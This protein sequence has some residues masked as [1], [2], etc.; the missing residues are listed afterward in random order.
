M[1]V[2]HSTGCTVQYFSDNLAIAKAIPRLE[3]KLL[4]ELCNHPAASPQPSPSRAHRAI[5]LAGLHT[6]VVSKV[7]TFRVG[8]SL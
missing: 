5:R 2:D 1:G 4:I 8:C 7:F 3:L 6:A